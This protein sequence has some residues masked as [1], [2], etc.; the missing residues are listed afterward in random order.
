MLADLGYAALPRNA[1]GT[2]T[3]DRSKYL[4]LLAAT[5]PAGKKFCVEQ[6]LVYAY[7]QYTLDTSDAATVA[8]DAQTMKLVADR[9]DPAKQAERLRAAGYTEES[10]SQALGLPMPVVSGFPWK[11]VALAG[12]GFLAWRWWRRRKAARS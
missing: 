12:G 9:D 4:K 7:H 1:D 8:S 6:P 10:I 2:C 5:D 11:W 3:Q